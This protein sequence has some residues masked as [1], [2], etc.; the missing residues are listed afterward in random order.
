MLKHSRRNAVASF[1]NSPC[2]H[3]PLALPLGAPPRAPWN[4]HTR[5]PRTAGARHWRWERLLVAEQ[6]GAAFNRSTG[7]ST[8]FIRLCATFCPIP[9]PL[10]DVP[11]D[12]LT[13]VHDV[14]VLD[15]DRLLAT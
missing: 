8:G 1:V 2:L 7:F 10:V 12:R 4:L 15:P 14:D 13:A 6:R 3:V 11:D 9:H 5:Q